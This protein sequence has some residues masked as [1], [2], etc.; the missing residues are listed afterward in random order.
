MTDKL[1]LA[2]ARNL[3][4]T[5]SQNYEINLSCQRVSFISMEIRLA[6]F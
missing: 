5:S 4:K 2:Y 1:Q 3:D 6:H